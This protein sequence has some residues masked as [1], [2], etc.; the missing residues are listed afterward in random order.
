MENSK[1][2]ITAAEHGAWLRE[3][4]AAAQADAEHARMV[5]AEANARLKRYG[6]ALDVLEQH[7]D[8]FASALHRGIREAQANGLDGDGKITTAFNEFVAG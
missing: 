1:V 3:R 5:L 7:R 2:V 8:A 6:T 4:Y